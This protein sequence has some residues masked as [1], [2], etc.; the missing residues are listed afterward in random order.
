MNHDRAWE[1]AGP[2]H[3]SLVIPLTYPYTVR[4]TLMRNKLIAVVLGALACLAYG[5]TRAFGLGLPPY[6][7]IYAVAL[8]L[9]VGVVAYGLLSIAWKSS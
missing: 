7:F 3:F 2:R 8:A 1:P 6:S 9:I 4:G 5:T